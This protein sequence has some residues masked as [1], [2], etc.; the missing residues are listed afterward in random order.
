MDTSN[1]K[2]TNKHAKHYSEDS[3][4]KKTKK[5][6]G[7]ASKEVLIKAFTLYYCLQDKDTPAWAK[8]VILG[9]L[10]YL[11][12]PIDVIPDYIPGIGLADDAAVLAGAIFT[13]ATHI[14]KEHTEKAE[15]QVSNL[16]G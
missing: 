10:G 4:W 5:I 6:V 2:T 1:I 12:S 16:L 3:F 8:A 7:K 9:A 13:I 11:I 14:K 15:N